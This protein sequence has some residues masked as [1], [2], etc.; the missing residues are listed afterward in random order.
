MQVLE[1]FSWASHCT[2]HMFRVQLSSHTH[3]VLFLHLHTVHKGTPPKIYRRGIMAG[4]LC[5]N[6]TK[7]YQHLIAPT[8]ATSGKLTNNLACV[9]LGELK[10]VPGGE[11]DGRGSTT[12]VG[13][14]GARNVIA[15]H[16]AQGTKQPNVPNA[17]AYCRS[18]HTVAQR[19]QLLMS[20][21][22]VDC[23]S[24]LWCTVIL[25]HIMDRLPELHTDDVLRPEDLELK[26]H[27]G[28]TPAQVAAG[29]LVGTVVGTGVQT[30]LGSV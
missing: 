21:V 24:C 6:S 20:I 12:P 3:C 16:T 18:F 26:I 19:P 27:L 7:S 22:P 29:F 25:N 23:L 1:P 10:A 30:F 9:T 28:H 8:P 5:L 4:H 13:P 11:G 17:H 2:V 14:F 15:P